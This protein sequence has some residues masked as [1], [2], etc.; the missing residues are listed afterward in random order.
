MK[1]KRFAWIVFSLLFLASL[2]A[3]DL[4]RGKIKLALNEKNGR[5]VLTYTDDIANPAPVTLFSSEDPTT[6]KLRVQ[7]GDKTHTIGD[8]PQFSPV[9]E[10]TPTGGKLTWTS[11]TLR[12]TQNFEFLTSL[13]S[14]VADG[15]KE[16]L[17]FTNLSETQ[18]TKLGVRLVVD[19]SLGEK[20]E[21]FKTSTSETISSESRLD[22]SLPDWWLSPSATDEKLGLLFMLGKGATAPNRVVFANWQRLDS[23]PWDFPFKQGRDFNFLP[24]SYNDSAVAHY[25]DG[26]DLAPNGTREIVLLFGNRSAITFANAKVGTANVLSDLLQESQNKDAG[27]PSAVAQDLQSL[28]DVVLQINAKLLD[29]TKATADDLKLFKAILDQLEARQ[30]VL[31]A[32][33]PTKTP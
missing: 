8:D 12:V 3:A 13:S 24:Y 2:P 28:E 7:W 11:K 10:L 5:F 23:S 31:A 17:T 15:V 29:P 20:K 4:Q 6:S 18:A 19:T 22:G 1:S 32:S 25:Y 27:G 9:F 21:H 30:A 16:T 26:Q 14:T 33:P